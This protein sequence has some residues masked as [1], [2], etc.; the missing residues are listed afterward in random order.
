MNKNKVFCVLLM[1][2]MFFTNAYSFESNHEEIVSFNTEEVIFHEPI[3]SLLQ[4]SPEQLISEPSMKQ[5]T[6]DF[7]WKVGGPITRD[8]LNHFRRILSEEEYKNIAIDTKIQV[9]NKHEYSNTPGWHCDFFSSSDEQED[10][11]VRANPGFETATRIFLLVSGEP[12]TEFMTPRNLKIDI[13]VPDWKQISKYLDS[14]INPTDLYQIPHATPVELRGNELHRVVAYEGENPTVRYFMRV[15]LFPEGHSQRGIYRN[16]LF[17]WETHP[18]I[19][20]TNILGDVNGFLEKAFSHL[21]EAGLDVSGYEMTH[22]CFRVASEG[23]FLIKK[24]ALSQVGTLISNVL[25]EGRP[26]LVY[27]LYDPIVYREHCVSLVAL[28]YPKPNNT[29]STALQHVAFLM[30]EDIST[31]LDQYPNIEFDK[32][33]LNRATHPELKLRFQ[34]LVIKFHNLSLEDLAQMTQYETPEYLYRIVSQDQWET[35]RLQ[36]EIVLSSIDEDFIHLA[37][38]DQ[39]AHVAHKFWNQMDYT[40]LKLD[41]KKLVGRLIYE[42]NPGGTTKYYHL[43]EGSIPLDAVVGVAIVNG[44]KDMEDL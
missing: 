36:N 26:Y 18:N 38:E 16:E 24:E 34:D 7:A 32:L 3:L 35:S 42:T 43:Y 40:I 14:N 27:K 25:A 15:Y 41:S 17:D 29:Y 5:A 21:T 20:T 10:R 44:D 12:A 11:L 13:N 2:A 37:T 9:I 39:V 31:L 30:K 1:L 8:I 33:E 4:A 23:G 6:A 19:Q 28:P 22:L